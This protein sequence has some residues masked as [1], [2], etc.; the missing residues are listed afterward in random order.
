MN[1][2]PRNSPRMYRAPVFTADMPL[3]FGMALTEHPSA[4]DRFQRLTDEEKRGLL[5]NAQS[6]RTK[7]E[8]RA[9]VEQ[10]AGSDIA[11]PT[12]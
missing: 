4:L 2:N 7:D 1:P 6:I 10:F 3:G 9:F 12:L 5:E 11:K 8:M